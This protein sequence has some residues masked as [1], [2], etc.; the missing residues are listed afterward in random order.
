MLRQPISPTFTWLEGAPVPN[1]EADTT[2]GAARA[3]VPTTDEFTK[4]FLR[5]M[6]FILLS[7]RNT[8]IFFTIL[9]SHPKKYPLFERLEYGV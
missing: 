3:V 1:I 2:I 9:S 7:F 8:Q 5:L 6:F 4:K